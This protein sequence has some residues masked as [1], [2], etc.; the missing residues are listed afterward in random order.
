MKGRV[1]AA[2]T[3]FWRAD[4]E[5]KG[6]QQWVQMKSLAAL[7]VGEVS[8]EVDGVDGRFGLEVEEVRLVTLAGVVSW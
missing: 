6:E 2:S 1:C 8:G 5:G 3:C 4:G 7:E